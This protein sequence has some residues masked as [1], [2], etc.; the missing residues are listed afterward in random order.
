MVFQNLKNFYLF[1]G[2]AATHYPGGMTIHRWS[3]IRDG[4]YDTATLVNLLTTLDIY[5]DC[6]QR[7][8]ETDVLLIDE[9]SMISSYIFDQLEAVCRALRKSDMLFGGLQLIVAGDFFQLRPV[10]SDFIPGKT[11]LQD[12]H[13]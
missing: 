3:G 5:E 12:R 1:T 6:R 8:R 10:P 13:I 4:K 2:I 11:N 9:I 7:V